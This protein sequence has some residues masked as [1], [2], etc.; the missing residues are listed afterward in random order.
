MTHW[1]GQC[2]IRRKR[3]AKWQ[4]QRERPKRRPSARG[5]RR[6]NRLA[7]ASTHGGAAPERSRSSGA[8]P[9]AFLSL[10][11]PRDPPYP[12]RL[13]RPLPQLSAR[14]PSNLA[15]HPP[16]LITHGWGQAWKG[17]CDRTHPVSDAAKN[18]EFSRLSV[19][20]RS[21]KINRSDGLQRF[22][23]RPSPRSGAP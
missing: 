1:I 15:R 21:C 16:G 3:K 11:H 2:A 7:S 12:S 8:A 18:R 6:N 13:P 23:T 17:G 14:N 22:D 20:R 4:Q 9:S 5:R 19:V 10:S